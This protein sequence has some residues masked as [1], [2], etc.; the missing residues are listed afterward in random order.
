MFR[1]LCTSQQLCRFSIR[2]SENALCSD[3]HNA[4]CAKAYVADNVDD[5]AD[6]DGDGD[7]DDDDADDD[8]SYSVR[9]HLHV[10]C[11]PRISICID[12]QVERVAYFIVVHIYWAHTLRS[13]LYN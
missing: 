7:D 10:Y 9:M 3:A 1:S 2:L 4:A 8:V 5:D 13:R 6:D 12:L 11:V